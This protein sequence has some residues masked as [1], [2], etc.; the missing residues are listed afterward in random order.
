MFPQLLL[1]HQTTNILSHCLKMALSFTSPDVLAVLFAA[2]GYFIWRV[3][4]YLSFV[5]GSPLRVLPGPPSPSWVY[6]NL[7]QIFATESAALPDKWFEQYGKCY[8]DY[9]FFMVRL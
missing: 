9:E 2:S 1:Q 8:V 7:K 6:G 4:K 3:F 5:Y